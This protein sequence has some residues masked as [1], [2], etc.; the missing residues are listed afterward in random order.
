[1][2]FLIRWIY[3]IRNIQKGK[4]KEIV[5]SFSQ[6]VPRTR[7]CIRERLNSLESF[8]SSCWPGIVYEPAAFRVPARDGTFNVLIALS[9]LAVSENVK[10]RPAQ[11]VSNN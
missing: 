7:R 5:V 1:M 2:P 4:L 3:Y 11:L 9:R 6:I 8:R 10:Y